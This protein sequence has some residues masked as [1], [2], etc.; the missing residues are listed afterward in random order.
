MFFSIICIIVGLVI[1]GGFLVTFLANKTEKTSKSTSLFLSALCFIP[2]VIS[3][4][5]ST[6]TIIPANHVGI[7]YNFFNGVQPTILREGRNSKGVF[8]TIYKI[9]T[10]TRTTVLEGVTG[11]T[12]DSQY[13][14]MNID[15]K[16][17]VNSQNA[18]EV[19]KQYKNLNRLEEEFIPPTVQRSI[20]A[21][22]V[23]YNVIDILGSERNKLYLAIEEEL[24]KR[25]SSSGIEFISVN[26]GD[27]DA[28]P[29]IEA[30]ITKEAVAKKE[31]ET[32]EQTKRMTEIEA[33]KKMIEAEAN[34]VKA[35]T[36]AETKIIQ[37]EAEAKANQL[38]S[39]SI[40]D[41]LLK[42]MEME[43]RLKHG[44]VTIQSGNVIT[45]TRTGN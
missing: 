23:E 25:F 35:Q 28:G 27:T 30:A 6:M 26:F 2:L 7:L 10:E 16:Y 31:A 40:S 39:N 9:S 11:Q 32:A 41:T 3:I 14:T 42:K 21:I 4:F 44:W 1:S 24:S 17:K 36:E 8:D 34:K 43:A 15:V 5:I 38:L 33:E 37:A 13:I 29:E 12:K 20:E 18:L 19:F 22:T 45:D